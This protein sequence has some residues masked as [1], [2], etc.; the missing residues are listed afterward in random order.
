MQEHKK[1]SEYIVCLSCSG[2]IQRAESQPV[3]WN[4]NYFLRFR[5][6]PLKRYGSGSGSGSDFRKS[7][8]YDSGSG[9]YFRKVTIPVPVPVPAP[10]LDH[11]KANFS[12][13]ILTNILPFYT[14]SCFTRKKFIN[15]NKFIVKYE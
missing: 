8:G 5:F 4:R 9:S 10:Y 12:K 3:L 11:K 14:V 7:Y 1:R 6:R 15:F 2:N 13:K